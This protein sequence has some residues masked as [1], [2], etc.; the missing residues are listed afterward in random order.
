MKERRYFDI[1]RAKI[2]GSQAVAVQAAAETLF[3]TGGRKLLAEGTQQTIREFAEQSAKATLGSLAPQA[4]SSASKV[5]TAGTARVAE[6]A[7]VAASSTKALS[8]AIAGEAGPLVVREA[9]KTAAKEVLKGVG[10]AAGVGLVV[11]GVFGGIQAATA[12]RKGEMTGKQAAVHTTKE[13]ATGAL[14]TG[15][16][17]ALAAGVVALTGG[18]A[19]PVVFVIGAGGA[20]GAKHGLR[21]LLS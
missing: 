3:E 9:A 17:V 5:M 6:M 2:A 13:A 15:A 19:A 20:I 8:R 16:G 11:D 14:A 21:R 4:L 7:E 1:I 12:Y 18:I 10:K